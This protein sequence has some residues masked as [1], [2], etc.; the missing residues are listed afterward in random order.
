MPDP[1][2]RLR[3]EARLVQGHAQQLECPLAMLGQRLQLAREGIAICL[4]RQPDRTILELGAKRLAVEVARALVEQARDHVGQALLARGI[5]SRA[6]LEVQGKRQE[7]DGVLGD[8]IGLDPAR[9]DHVLDLA[10]G[11]P[12]RRRA[13]RAGHHHRS[14]Q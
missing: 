3:I 13:E 1:L 7:R 8:Q 12:G 2:D 10:R 9:A 14:D 11:L 5:E 6:A 4:E